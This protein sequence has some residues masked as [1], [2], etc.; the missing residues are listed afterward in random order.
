MAHPCR[1]RE[2]RV[3]GSCVGRVRRF[4]RGAVCLLVLFVT[5]ACHKTTPPAPVKTLTLIDQAWSSREYQRRLNDEL[6]RFTQQTGIQVEFLP[7]PETAG[8]QLATFRNLLENGTRGPDVYG[9]DVVFPGIL[10]DDLLDLRA[11]V[12]E[13]EIQ[14]HLPELI[15]N[16]TVNGR[17]VA[18]KYRSMCPMGVRYRCTRPRRLFK[19]LWPRPGSGIG[20]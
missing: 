12:P 20:K 6:A 14:A 5:Q 7:A 11:Y 8:E 9:I 15:A 19:P 18:S 13:Q 2:N 17:L 3:C 16:N 1:T 10:A 4:A